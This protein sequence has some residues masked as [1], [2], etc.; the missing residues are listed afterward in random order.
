MD[1]KAFSAGVLIISIIIVAVVVS[2]VAMFYLPQESAV[3][4][5][6]KQLGCIGVGG[7]LVGSQVCCSGLSAVGNKCVKGKKVVGKNVV[8]LAERCVSEIR[9]KW[10]AGVCVG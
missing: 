7:K 9:G 4:G 2:G 8:S 5:E 10:V 6:A 3:A 1:K